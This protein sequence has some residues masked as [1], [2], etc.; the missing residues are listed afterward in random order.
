MISLETELDTGCS[1]LLRLLM[2]VEKEVFT[3]IAILLSVLVISSISINVIFSETDFYLKEG[4]NFSQKV[5]QL[6]VI[7]F[8]FKLLLQVI[9]VLSLPSIFA[10]HQSQHR[11]IFFIPLFFSFHFF[12]NPK[13]LQRNMKNQ[14]IEN[15]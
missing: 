2:I 12:F 10:L 14:L 13:A 8:S 3:K 4:L 5:S 6:S 15:Y 11:L 7:F 9:L 1:G